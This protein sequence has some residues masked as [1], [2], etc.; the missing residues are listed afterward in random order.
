ML[1]GRAPCETGNGHKSI[2]GISLYI[3]SLRPGVSNNDRRAYGHGASAI[4]EIVHVD[5]TDQMYCVAATES[6]NLS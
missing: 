1:S 4:P 2:C 5:Q 6:C 3:M